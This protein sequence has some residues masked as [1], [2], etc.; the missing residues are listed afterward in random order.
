[1]QLITLEKSQTTKLFWLIIGL[2]LGV[3]VLTAD[4]SDPGVMA[5]AVLLAL[6]AAF[7][8]Y[9]WL[10]GSSHGLPIWPVFSLVT[11]VTYA[12]PMIQGSE[13]LVGYTSTDIIT[14]GITTIGFI[15]LGTMIWLSMTSRAPKAPRT[16]LM[17]EQAHAVRYLLI[18]V[19]LGLLFGIN[20][21]T[22]WIRL[23]GNSM[24]VLRGITG[25]LSTMGLFVLAYYHGRGLLSKRDLIIFAAAAVATM[26]MNMTSLMLAQ[27]MVPVAMVIF[28]YMLGSN[29]LPWKILLVTFVVM[30]LLH[31]G[32]Y[33]MRNVYWAGE[34]SKPV[35]LATVPQFYWDWFSYGFAEVGSLAGI[36]SGPKDEDS[37]TSVFERSGNLH[38]L[39]LVQKKT[40][41]EVPYFNGATYAPIPRLL[42]PRFIDD[43]KGIS[44]A[45]N[46]MLTV[47]YGLQT[48]EQT[49][50]TSIGWGLLPEAY[51]NFGYI[52]IAGLAVVLAFFYALITNLTVGV[53]MTSLRFV[54]GLLIM[55]AATRAD[56]MGVF[57][58][59]QFQGVIGVSLAAM[60]LMRRQRNPFAAESGETE[61]EARSMERGAG[62]WGTRRQG[63][64]SGEH[65]ARET[66]AA[67][68]GMPV[69]GILATLIEGAP[70][71][72]AQ[73]AA[74][75]MER[76]AEGKQ[77]PADARTHL[78]ADGAVVRTMPI[79]TPKR[80]ASWMP[81][82]VRAAVVA[83]YAAEDAP[84]GTET[85]KGGSERPRQLAVPYQNY[86]RYRA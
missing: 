78:A 65:G 51:A 62:K 28:G 38:M 31:P 80:I 81:R 39:L 55:A 85:P 36:V 1:M 60:V 83:Q 43:Q 54:L 64:W 30:S 79:R 66:Q 47:N 16:V 42:I 32:K 22:G 20:Q 69:P 3:S 63:A 86:R 25:S 72:R 76:G 41:N 50:S 23:P 6:A 4:Q 5:T 7:P 53:P 68:L 77:N 82:R 44:H 12:L 13:A 29:Q 71:V 57:V 74:S 34:E 40:P 56:T 45:G 75:S 9:L 49:A 67:E 37:P 10:L 24:Q 70:E 11:G 19:G 48:I 73:Q 59:T 8:F 33:E 58:T 61:R 46:V 14:G 35:T 18:F 15:L 27:A 26:L 84:E 52:G 21:L 2:L 17:I